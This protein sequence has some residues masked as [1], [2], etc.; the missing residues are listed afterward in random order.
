MCGWCREGWC[1]RIIHPRPFTVSTCSPM[2]VLH[3]FVCFCFG[4]HHGRFCPIRVLSQHKSGAKMASNSV[5]LVAVAPVLIQYCR[6]CM[7]N[8]IDNKLNN[9]ICY[10]FVIA[11]SSTGLR[12]LASS[13]KQ[14]ISTHSVCCVSMQLCWNL[15]IIWCI[16]L[17]FFVEIIIHLAIKICHFTGRKI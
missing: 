12:E 17:D 5:T 11:V 15:S 2:I 7:L 1:E 8:E 6:T 10:I 13:L 3:I 16:C 4:N 14:S 9:N